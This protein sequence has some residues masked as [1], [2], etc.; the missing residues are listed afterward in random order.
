MA[1][2][3]FNIDSKLDQTLEDLKSHY[4]AAS[5]AEVLRKAIALLNVVSRNENED[6]SVTIRHENQDVKVILR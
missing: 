6:G 4:G 3:S 1:T 5:K 2:T